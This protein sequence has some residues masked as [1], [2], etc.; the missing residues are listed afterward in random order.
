MSMKRILLLFLSL[1][2]SC[3]YALAETRYE[4]KLKSG[5]KVI[6]GRY[7]EEKGIVKCQKG[8]MVVGFRKDAILSITEI[9]DT[10]KGEETSAAKTDTPDTGKQSESTEEKKEAAAASSSTPTTLPAVGSVKDPVQKE[11]LI[12]KSRIKSNI[13]FAIEKMRQARVRKDEEDYQKA[14]GEM[15]EFSRQY[16]ALEREVTS[17]Y[18]GKLPAWWKE[19]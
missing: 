14:V 7:W 5:G 1:S 16:Y 19:N 13:E 6:A 12:R 3:L 2:L 17:K 9:K 4:I 11:I 15:N 10:G 8:E 18:D